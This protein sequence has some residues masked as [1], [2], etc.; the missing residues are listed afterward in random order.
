ETLHDEAERLE[1]EL[2]EVRRRLT[3]IGRDRAEETVRAEVLGRPWTLSLP[4]GRDVDIGSGV[5]ESQEGEDIGEDGV[6]LEGPVSGT[7]SRARPPWANHEQVEGEEEMEDRAGHQRILRALSRAHRQREQLVEHL[8]L[9][10]KERM[11][12]EKKNARLVRVVLEQVKEKLLRDEEGGGVREA[13]DVIFGG[14]E[15]SDGKAPDLLQNAQKEILEANERMDVLGVNGK[16]EKGLAQGKKAEGM[17]AMATSSIDS[18]GGFRGNRTHTAGMAGSYTNK[19]GEKSM[20]QA[21]LKGRSMTLGPSLRKY[22]SHHQLRPPSSSVSSQDASCRSPSP[23]KI[24]RSHPVTSTT[25]G[26]ALSGSTEGGDLGGQE[27]SSGSGGKRGLSVGRGPKGTR[28]GLGVGIGLSPGGGNPGIRGRSV[29]HGGFTPSNPDT[30]VNGRSSQDSSAGE[31]G[32][33]GEVII[34]KGMYARRA[35]SSTMLPQFKSGTEGS[36][37]GHG[38]GSHGSWGSTSSSGSTLVASDESQSMNGK[39]KLGLGL[40]VNARDG[41]KSHLFNLSHSQ[42][43]MGKGSKLLPPTRL[44]KGPTQTPGA[45]NEAKSKASEGE[46]RREEEDEDS[47]SRYGYTMPTICKPGSDDTGGIGL[48]EDILSAN[49]ALAREMMNRS[50]TP[51]TARFMGLDDL[52]APPSFPGR[53]P[54]SPTPPPVPPLLGE[55]RLGG[56]G[57]SPNLAAIMSGEAPTPSPMSSLLGS[58]SVSVT[59][60]TSPISSTHGDI[61]EA[62]GITPGSLVQGMGKR[63]AQLNRRDSES[64]TFGNPTSRHS[65]ADLA[66]SPSMCNGLTPPDEREEEGEEDGERGCR[67]RMTGARDDWVVGTGVGI[68]GRTGIPQSVPPPGTST[69]PPRMRGSTQPGQMDTGSKAEEPTIHLQILQQAKLLAQKDAQV[70]EELVGINKLRAEINLLDRAI[71]QS[72]GVGGVRPRSGTLPVVPQRTRAILTR[73]QEEYNVRI[74][75]LS[76]RC[77][78]V[79]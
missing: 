7:P 16:G 49:A 36:G 27:E 23:S 76:D 70:S 28:I 8:H 45:D 9:L 38:K 47:L 52:R 14:E 64:D 65:Q 67:D 71:G 35:R 72:G 25:S 57:T 51:N 44:T 13:V 5:E 3:G 56:L 53:S 17:G 4:D 2:G 50:A 48:P 73:K 15:P 21:S 31:V 33:R 41:G 77:S 11:S 66:P 78:Q 60:V 6:N 79:S 59:E 30:T 1:T 54:M 37:H 63:P 26:S 10:S 69:P 39:R 40:G 29:S 58:T 74:K 18:K 75:A 32:G 61:V 19:A 68:G 12:L 62:G 20:D 22:K 55:R 24:P 43:R 46:D 34:G 42:V